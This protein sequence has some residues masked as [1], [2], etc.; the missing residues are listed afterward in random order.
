[1]SVGFTGTFDQTF[2]QHVE[3]IKRLVEEEIPGCSA[4]FDPHAWPIV[5]FRIQ[6][7]QG[8]IVSKAYSNFSM[9]ELEKMADRKLRS[10]IRRRCETPKDDQTF[11][12]K[13]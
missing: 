4:V 13:Q 3:R 1:V 7:A 9:A 12:T 11:L 2:G 8:A 6:D 10:V 5:R